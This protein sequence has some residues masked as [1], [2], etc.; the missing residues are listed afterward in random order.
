MYNYIIISI[1]HISLF[2]E[3]NFMFK[4]TINLF[5]VLFVIIIN[6]SF[7]VVLAYNDS[8]KSINLFRKF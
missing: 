2:A 7:H 1:E 6:F 3:N 8:K 5:I 4:F